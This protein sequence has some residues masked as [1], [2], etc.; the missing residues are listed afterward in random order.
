M[1]ATSHAPMLIKLSQFVSSS[2]DAVLFRFMNPYSLTSCFIN[3][4]TPTVDSTDPPNIQAEEGDTVM[5]QCPFSESPLGD[6]QVSLLRNDGGVISVWSTLAGE[7]ANDLV[8][9]NVTS[10][11][12]GM[13]FCRLKDTDSDVY[14]GPSF[15][16]QVFS[17]FGEFHFLY[18]MPQL[19]V[20][21]KTCKRLHTPAYNNNQIPH[22]M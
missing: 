8:L 12:S 5:I 21:L 20:Y 19:K 22:H 7:G 14:N 13:Y 2:M 4:V 10:E 11:D 16:L 6:Y 15:R 18:Y 9:V 17:K 3:I 1:Y